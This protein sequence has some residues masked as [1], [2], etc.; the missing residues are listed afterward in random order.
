[1]DLFTRLFIDVLFS[2]LTLVV[3]IVVLAVAVAVAFVPT[4]STV[5]V[6]AVVVVVV[7]VVVVVA[8]VTGPL[9]PLGVEF[10]FGE[11]LK[12]K[13]GR[14]LLLCGEEIPFLSLF[15]QAAELLAA[16]DDKEDK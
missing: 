5:A 12:L 15:L 7:D 1:V 14:L 13:L 4:V 10:L 6:V 8:G 2:L 11:T 9:G 3:V 16:E